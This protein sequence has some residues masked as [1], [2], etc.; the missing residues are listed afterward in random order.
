MYPFSRDRKILIGVV[1]L[2]PLPGAPRYARGSMEAVL[3]HARADALAWRDGGAD[4]VLVEN[5]GDVPFFAGC[6]PPETVAGLALA[7]D[8]V[9][10]VVGDLPTGVNCLRNDARAALGLCAATGAAFVRVNVHTGAAV[11]DQGVIEGRAAET[12]RERERLCPDVALFADV[13]VKH[14]AS[15]ASVPLADAADDAVRRGLA[16]AL[17]LTG[18][19]TG[20]AGA[21]SDL[22][23]VRERLGDVPLFVGSGFSPDEAHEKLAIADGAIVGTWAK[24]GGEVDEPVDP[25]R[26][27]RLRAACDRA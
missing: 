18:S 2:G 16:D 4:A 3:T 11:T 14:A 27:E 22:A 5:F 19:S 15:L 12:L 26:V 8:D 9:L 21:T 25:A 23:V 24:H 17:V 10:G 1:H 7:L 20:R 6:L 13:H